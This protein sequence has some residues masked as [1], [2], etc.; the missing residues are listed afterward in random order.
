MVVGGSC[1]LKKVEKEE[2]NIKINEK[3]IMML[4]L[5]IILMRCLILIGLV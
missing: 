4:I 1:R 2:K 3:K 5:F